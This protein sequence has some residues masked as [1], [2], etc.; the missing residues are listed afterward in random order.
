MAV[1]PS[2]T[3]LRQHIV[4]NVR[5]KD[6]LSLVEWTQQVRRL[7]DG[8]RIRFRDFAPYQVEPMESF[9]DPEVQR[10][11]LMWGS[12]LGK[13][14]T[15]MSA[16]GYC[17]EH[18]P[19]R[20]LVMYPTVSQ[21]EKWS[22]ETLNKELVECIE[23]I[24]KMLGG[25]MGKR[26]ADNTILHKVFPGGLLNIF[27]A[28]SPGE[29]RRAKGNFLFADEIDAFQSKE[30]DE[31]EGAIPKFDMAERPSLLRLEYEHPNERRKDS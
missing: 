10:T 6:R 14:F 3:F 5:L 31:G 7:E 12:R 4:A 23:P 16:L 9:F 26:N 2:L 15:M 17:I 28:N 21:A 8:K 13:T 29:M 30:S 25:Q 27:G 22:K 18:D 19:R 20:I 1:S 24:R 11:V